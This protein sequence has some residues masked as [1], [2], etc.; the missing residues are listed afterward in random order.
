[1]ILNK[2]IFII[3]VGCAAVNNDIDKKAYVQAIVENR[4]AY[5]FIFIVA[6]SQLVRSHHTG[7]H[8]SATIKW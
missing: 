3:V 5:V 1:M 7:G 8:Q 6:E 4:I 2:N